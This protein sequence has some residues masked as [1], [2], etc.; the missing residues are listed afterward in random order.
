M[1]GIVCSKRPQ[2]GIDPPVAAASVYGV[3]ALTKEQLGFPFIVIF[4]AMFN[5]GV[6]FLCTKKCFY[7]FVALVCV[8]GGG[9]NIRNNFQHT[10]LL[11][12]FACKHT[13]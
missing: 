13:Y 6:T 8:G 10:A 9:H 2:A 1:G 12:F 3:H 7:Y 5:G 4:E 11:D